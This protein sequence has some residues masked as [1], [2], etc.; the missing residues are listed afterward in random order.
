MDEQNPDLIVVSR[1]ELTKLIEGEI[2][3]VYDQAMHNTVGVLVSWLETQDNPLA[4]DIINQLRQLSSSPS[5]G[6]L[7]HD[8]EQGCQQCPLGRCAAGIN[9]NGG[10][11]VRVECIALAMQA[12]ARSTAVWHRDLGGENWP[13]PAWCPLRRGS[14]CV[15]AATEE[16]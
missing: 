9:I 3:R 8:P 6:V 12:G 11:C 1:A 13:A 7:K 15:T 5:M 16:T 4:V 14:M 10:P 2:S